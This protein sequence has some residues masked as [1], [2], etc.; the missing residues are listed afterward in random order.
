[1]SINAKSFN[2]GS[3]RRNDTPKPGADFFDTNN[4][5]GERLRRAAAEAAVTDMLKWFSEGG[6]VGVLDATNSTKAR[7]AWIKEQCESRGYQVLFVESKCENDDII[8]NNI[9]DVKVRSPDYAGVDPE[10]AANDFMERI[11]NYERVYQSIDGDE[12][13][14]LTYVQLVDVGSSVVINNIENYLQTRIIYFT[15]NLH[16]TPRSIY[17]SRVCNPFI[18]VVLMTNLL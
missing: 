13:S 16:I 8:M 14:D 1:M 18:P 11:R 3:Y 2:V 15:M 6:H 12:E 4:P 17:L 10:T 9:K 5:K 7:R